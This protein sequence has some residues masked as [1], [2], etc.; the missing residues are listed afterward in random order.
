MPIVAILGGDIIAPCHLEPATDV[1]HKTL[2]WSRLDLKPRFVHVRRDGVELLINQNPSYVGRTS[3]STNNLKHGDVS[4]K[5]SKVRL[6]DAGTYRCHIPE[7]GT[8]VVKLIVGA[9][10]SPV[11]IIA[12]I[13][14][15]SS[16]AVLQCESKG[17]YPEPEVFWLDGE[18]TLLSA[19]PTETVRGP[20]DLYTVSSRVTVEKR[21]SNSFTCRVQQKNIKQT[22]ETEIQI[23]DNKM[24][25]DNGPR[26][27]TAETDELVDEPKKREDQLKEKLKEKEEEQNDIRYLI[28]VLEEKKKELENSRDKL[29]LQIEEVEKKMKKNEKEINSLKNVFHWDKDDKMNKLLENS[30]MFRVKDKRSLKPQLSFSSSVVIFYRTVGLLLLTRYS[31]GQFK[32]VGPPEPIA[33][34]AGDDIILPCHLNPAKEAVSMTVEWTRP[35]LTPRYVHVRRGGEDLL[36]GQNLMYEGRTSMFINKLKHGDTSLRLSNVKLSDAGK[37]R[38]FFPDYNRDAFVEL[39]VGAVSSPVI[40]SINRASTGLVLQCESKGWYPEPEVF[41]LDAEGN[42]LSAGPTETVRGPDDL[43]TVSR[44]LTVEK[45]D[46]F[47]CRVQQKNITQTR[48]TE[49]QILDNKM[50]HDNE[51]EDGTAETDKLVEELKKMEDQLKEKLKEKEEEQNDIRDVISV[52][53][54]NKK[55]LENSRDKLK[56]QIEEVE[57]K[58]KKSQFRVVGPP[59]PIVAALGDDIILPC[60]LKPAVDASEMTIEWSRPDLDPRFVLVWRDGVKLE[61]KQHPSYN[62]RTSLFNDELKYGDVSL[63]LSKVKLSDEGKY[64][65]FIPTSFKE[66]TVELVVGVVSFIVI[67][68]A[69]TDEDKVGTGLVLQCESKGWYPEPEV[70]WLDPEGSLLSAGP[71]ETVRGPDDL[72]TV[73]RRLTVEKS[74]NF[75]CRVQQKN[76]TQ[77]RETHFYVPDKKHDGCRTGE[78]EELINGTTKQEPMELQPK[79]IIDRLSVVMKKIKEQQEEVEKEKMEI[80]KSIELLGGFFG[81]WLSDGK[82]KKELEDKKTKWEKLLQSIK[83]TEGVIVE[84]NTQLEETKGRRDEIQLEKE[85]ETN[86]NTEAA[87][88]TLCPDTKPDES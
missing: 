25:H 81:F 33:T 86:K 16:T 31:E 21:Y 26:D 22:R 79:D 18:G 55:E 23:L 32:V 77:T 15:A 39:V 84:I 27:G 14:K 54:E 88:L 58:M 7:L 73:S 3:V 28:S 2:E 87:P 47:T 6:T 34:I 41:W 38:C 62:G 8:S 11:V 50:H 82:K 68:L 30:K 65:C 61:N 4:L 64:R 10:S 36:V 80:E 52:L 12:Q 48:E 69:R 75:I 59:Q 40:V 51:P 78:R 29:K 66:S 83:E 43:Y 20:D 76:I 13:D 5:L 72:Y 9:L 19:G 24:Y 42:L 45:S 46:T 85:E 1:V 60:H 37:Y 56:S 57:K 71:T 53:E 49:I 67:R 74:D 17:W 44:R 63:K 70:F 35:D